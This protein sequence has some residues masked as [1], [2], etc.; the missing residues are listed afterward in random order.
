MD[1]TGH[2]ASAARERSYL[3]ENDQA[4]LSLGLSEMYVMRVATFQLS[5]PITSAQDVNARF[6][7]SFGGVVSPSLL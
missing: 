7:G 1:T 3:T 4:H 5:S 2:N 6:S